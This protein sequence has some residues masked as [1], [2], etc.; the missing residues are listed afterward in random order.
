MKFSMIDYAADPPLYVC[1]PT[2]VNDTTFPVPK[3]T[4]PDS[5]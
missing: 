5:V 1:T 2:Y 4:D 3:H